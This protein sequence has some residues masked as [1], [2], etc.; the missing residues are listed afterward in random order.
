VLERDDWATLPQLDAT[1]TVRDFFAGSSRERQ[2]LT[3][4]FNGFAISKPEAYRHFRRCLVAAGDKK[5]ADAVREFSAALVCAGRSSATTGPNEE[6]VGE[7]H[8][9]EDNDDDGSDAEEESDDNSNDN[10]DSLEFEGD[11]SE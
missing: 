7:E 8:A 4:L 1:L 5:I 9:Q 2:M 11:R 6:Y 3:R 10:S